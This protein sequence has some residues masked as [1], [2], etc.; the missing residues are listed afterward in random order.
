MPIVIYQN[1]LIHLVGLI[2]SV[3]NFMTTILVSAY[4]HY[5]AFVSIDQPTDGDPIQKNY[6]S[7][8]IFAILAT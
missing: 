2:M 8:L 5:L 3:K 4:N 6:A 1:S 7:A